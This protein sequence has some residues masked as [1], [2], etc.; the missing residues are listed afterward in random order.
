MEGRGEDGEP[1][2]ALRRHRGAASNSRATPG[3]GA[4]AGNMAELG[5][6]GEAVLLR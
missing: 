4:S 1:N 3:I 2:R 6:A 5:G